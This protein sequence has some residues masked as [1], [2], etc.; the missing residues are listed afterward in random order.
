MQGSRRRHRNCA[1]GK[2]SRR[3]CRA[4]KA[5]DLNWV[6]YW[7]CRDRLG[8]SVGKG[9]EDGSD[10]SRWG[11]LLWVSG[12]DHLVWILFQHAS[13]ADAGWFRGLD[14]RWF[15]Q[16]HRVFPNG[17]ASQEGTIQK[18]NEV[19]SINGKSLKGA[20]HSDALAI[21]RQA[22]D[23]RQAVIV[24]RKPVLEATPDLN[25]SSDS[26]TAAS[27][28]SDVSADS[29]KCLQA[30]GRRWGSHCLWPRGASA[31]EAPRSCVACLDT[32]G[33]TCLCPYVRGHG[34]KASRQPSLAH[35]GARSGGR[36]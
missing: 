2:H 23:P 34:C 21:L 25:S 33:G 26:T 16:V 4:G 28:A 20:T 36:P 22:R 14:F 32:A 18:G 13:G 19:L 3:R 10:H 5:R 6:V 1:S 29:S 15:L 8:H 17:L 30:C 31:A 9:S 11:S 7:D 12:F 27:E 35:V 24:T